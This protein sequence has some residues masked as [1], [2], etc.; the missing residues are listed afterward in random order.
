MKKI[1]VAGLFL[2]LTGCV[3][4]NYS[5]LSESQAT[6]SNVQIEER[7]N[8]SRRHHAVTVSF[9][10]QIENFHEKRSLYWCSVQFRTIDDGSFTI[11]RESPKPCW[12][13]DSAGQIEI[14]WPMPIDR[15]YSN[16]VEPVLSALKYPI[17]FFVAIHQE[18][19]NRQHV[20]IGQ[21][22]T[23]VSELELPS[24]SE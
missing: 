15:H 2:F 24:A 5:E 21:S 22:D 7:H 18:T 23:F 13:S 8:I 20:T 11:Q 1:A 10:Y 9:D 16:A 6:L 19:G 17:E 3:T 12:I 14:T 4:T